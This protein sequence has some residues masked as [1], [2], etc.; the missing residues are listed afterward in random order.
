MQQLATSYSLVFPECNP[1]AVPS[2]ASRIYAANGAKVA[3]LVAQVDQHPRPT[4]SPTRT[5]HAVRRPER[6]ARAVRAL[7]ATPKEQLL[8]AAHSAGLA[9]AGQGDAHRGRRRQGAR[10]HGA[11]PVDHAPA[12]AEDTAA[13]DSS[14]SALLKLMVDEF[15][16]GLRLG[17]AKGERLAGR[18]MLTNE[19][20]D[21]MRT[22][23]V[24]YGAM[25]NDRRRLRQDAGSDGAP[26]H[27]RHAGQ[28]RDL[29]L[30]LWADDLISARTATPTSARWPPTARA[31]IRS[32][33]IRASPEREL[34]SPWR[35]RQPAPIVAGYKT[36]GRSFFFDHREVCMKLFRSLA[37]LA[38]AAALLA[39]C[40]GGDP[41]VPGS[42][43][44]CGAPTTGN[45]TAA[46]ISFGDS[47]SDVGSYRRRRPSSV[48]RAA[49]SPP[50]G[51]PERSVENVATTLGL[52]RHARRG[53]LQRAIGEVPGR[54]TRTR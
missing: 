18:T 32:D 22:F 15:N 21:N 17:I 48:S 16:A 28:R 30:H 41:D 13:G 31:R 12:R 37:P 36:N 14:R 44:P 49:S 35:E 6:P 45:F 7:P 4:P 24:S 47:L 53:R 10:L 8:T 40:G 20:M 3:D 26:V 42:G 51:R 11:Q 43:S 29:D 38:L 19:Q 9:L 1:N 39:A 50:T 27:Q 34:V 5:R 25:T 52:F 46:F 2:P 23:P 33:R 54:P